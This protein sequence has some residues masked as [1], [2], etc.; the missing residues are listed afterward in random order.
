MFFLLIGK[1]VLFVQFVHEKGIGDQY[2]DEAKDRT[3]LSHPKTERG[4]AKVKLVQF[5][6]I[7][8]AAPKGHGEPDYEETAN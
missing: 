1:A 2:G 6:L 3:L 7:K 5:F 8:D 4:S